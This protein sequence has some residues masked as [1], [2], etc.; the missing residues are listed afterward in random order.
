MF[1]SSGYLS[2]PFTLAE[3]VAKMRAAAE[4]YAEEVAAYDGD[5]ILFGHNHLQFCGEV[6]GKLLLNAGSCG[7]PCD[8]DTRAPYALLRE[9]S[10]GVAAELRRVEYDLSETIDATRN[11]DF[12]EKA[13]F[14]CEIH[15][16]MLV[17]AKDY[18]YDFWQHL[19]TIDGYSGFPIPN[20][21]WRRGIET[22][23]IA[24]LFSKSN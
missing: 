19:K 10:A 3:G 24:S 11:S 14:W 4:Q 7:L 9:E 8:Y 2:E 22:F 21:V 23:D 18:M 1:H 15:F 17:Q 6:A 20:D 13:K 16:L 5:V 12:Y